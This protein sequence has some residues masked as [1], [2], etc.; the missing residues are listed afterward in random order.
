MKQNLIKRCV[1]LCLVLSMT[2]GMGISSYALENVTRRAEEDDVTSYV[3]TEKGRIG[4][5]FHVRY[6]TD[7]I[8]RAR[9]LLDCWGVVHPITGTVTEL[10]ND[11]LEYPRL[12]G[13]L[14]TNR[15]VVNVPGHV[16]LNEN[17]PAVVEYLYN[18]YT[19]SLS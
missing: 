1:C 10:K 11:D 2:L 5:L 15:P 18:N 13:G 8:P 17:S 14:G 9:T 6:G 7:D 12:V 4:A 3:S 16:F 19:F